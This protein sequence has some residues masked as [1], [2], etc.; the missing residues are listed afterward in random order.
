[1]WGETGSGGGFRSSPVW[2]TFSVVPRRA[3]SIAFVRTRRATLGAVVLC[4]S[5]F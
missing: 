3:E 4:F 5:W 2:G 1:M